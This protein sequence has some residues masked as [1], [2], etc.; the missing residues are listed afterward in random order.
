[1]R[2]IGAV[3]NCQDLA[4]GELSSRMVTPTGSLDVTVS[5]GALGPLRSREQR[6]KVEGT[7]NFWKG[8]RR[9]PGGSAKGE[10]ADEAWSGSEECRRIPQTPYLLKSHTW[11]LCGD[12]C[13]LVTN[14]VII[15][16]DHNHYGSKAILAF[17]Y[18]LIF[19]FSL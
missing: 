4:P 2:G 3:R 12:L 7:G 15:K 6:P 16:M 10:P 1:M 17:S 11:L 18:L 9:A 8:S 19:N 5:A 13:I 14:A